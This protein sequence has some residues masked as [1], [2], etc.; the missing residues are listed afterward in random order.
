MKGTYTMDFTYLKEFMDRLTAEKVPGNSIVVYHKNQEVFRYNSGYSDAENKIPMT[1]DELLNIYS[2]SK[3]ATVVAALQ[4]YEKGYFLLDDPLYTYMPEFKDMNVL[5]EDGTLSKAKNPITMRHLF[6]MSTGFTYETDSPSMLQAIRDTNGKMPTVQALRYL[7][8]EPLVFEPGTHWKYSLSHDVLAAVVEIISG[9]RFQDYMKENVFAPIG[10][11]DIHYHHTEDTL[12]RTASQYVF[13][14]GEEIDVAKGQISGA[15]K[16]GHWVKQGKDNDLVLG[17]EYDSGGA[18]VIV[19]VADYAK[20][21]SC[22][23]NGGKAPN[24]E[25]ILSAGTID[26]LRTNQLNETQL[27]DFNWSQFSGYGYGLGVRTMIDKKTA[28]FNGISGEFG[29]GGAAGATILVDPDN[30][31]SYFYAHHM[32]VPQEEYYQPRLRN[33]VFAGFLK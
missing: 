4:L 17:E 28:G 3:P 30:N 23:A 15:G 6:T 9:M 21:A 24:G 14:T 33:V 12:A 22:L 29:W 16:S 27:K 5:G 10:I 1:G 32:L 11:E 25:S 19:S 26:L 7:A 8:K 18:G 13:M 31:F 2:C 20:F